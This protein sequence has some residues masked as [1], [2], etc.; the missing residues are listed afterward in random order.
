MLVAVAVGEI[1]GEM[2]GPVDA[3]GEGLIELLGEDVEEALDVG[4][5]EVVGNGEDVGDGE[6][7]GMG[8]VVGIGE[9]VT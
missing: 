6:A 8:E 5:E 9:A 7:V 1:I 4:E 3:V 2:L